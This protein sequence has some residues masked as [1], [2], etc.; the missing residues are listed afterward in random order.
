MQDELS[1]KIFS[2]MSA[3]PPF[4]YISPSYVL[5]KAKHQFHEII[6][7]TTTLN[8][9][10]SSGSRLLIHKTLE[11]IEIPISLSSHMTVG[12]TYALDLLEYQLVNLYMI[13]LINRNH[14]VN[15]P[16]TEC[17]LFCI[18]FLINV[19]SIIYVHK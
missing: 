8:E 7:G 11:L 4:N 6:S 3:S 17:I 13:G 18:S 15:Q 10:T 5:R 12:K 1:L 9:K 14:F 2:S 19:F 16:M